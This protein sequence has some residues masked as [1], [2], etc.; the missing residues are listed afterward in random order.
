M[1][2]DTIEGNWQQFKGRMKKEWS[3]FT[4][5][6][7]D[8]IA[9][10]R[11]QLSSKIQ[12]FYGVSKEA[13]DRPSPPIALRCDQQSSRLRNFSAIMLNVNNAGILKNGMTGA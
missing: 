6:H 4:D 12:E 5:E 3:A 1:T 10:Q 9:G 13:A 11:D 8:S 7:L 2:W